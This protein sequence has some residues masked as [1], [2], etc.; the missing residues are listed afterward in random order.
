MIESLNSPDAVEGAFA[1]SAILATTAGVALAS[2]FPFL[3]RFAKAS[4]DIQREQRVERFQDAALVQRSQEQHADAN[5]RFAV[6]RQ[7]NGLTND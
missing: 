2:K 7:E 1:V 6:W 4:R 5:A 3:V